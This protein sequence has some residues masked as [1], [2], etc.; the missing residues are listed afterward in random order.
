MKR[1][2]NSGI[3]PRI[4]NIMADNHE[5]ISEPSFKIVMLIPEN[6]VT[7]RITTNDDSSK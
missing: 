5:F 7:T 2:I 6:I 3:N 1:I 4:Y